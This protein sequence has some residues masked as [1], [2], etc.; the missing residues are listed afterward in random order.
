MLDLDYFYSYNS[1]G[2][3]VLKSR[4]SYKSYLDLIR[5]IEE[6]RSTKSISFHL[7]LAEESSKWEWY[8]KYKLWLNSYEEWEKLKDSHTATENPHEFKIEPPTKPTFIPF[9]YS[10]KI[11]QV[12]LNQID[13]QAGEVRKV[14]A[15]GELIEEEY[16]IAERDAKNWDGQGTPPLSISLWADVAGLSYEDA[17]NQIVSMS[18]QFERVLLTIRQIRLQTKAAIKNSELPEAIGFY[19]EALDSFKEIRSSN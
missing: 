16:R 13:V 7:D 9:W 15:T 2:E 1:K 14:F 8:E 6:N 10:E 3:R 12:M 11:K 18:K 17:A 4:S 5:V 19:T